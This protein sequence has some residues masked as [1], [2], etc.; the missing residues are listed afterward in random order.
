MRCPAEDGS[1]ARQ[2]KRGERKRARVMKPSSDDDGGGAE[3]CGPAAE[4]EQCSARGGAGDRA[5]AVGDHLSAARM[6]Y[7]TLLERLG[8]KGFRYSPLG[9][10]DGMLAQMLAEVDLRARVHARSR[11]SAGRACWRCAG[12]TAWI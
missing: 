2:A 11:R 1:N 5:E 8:L 3:D 10:R 4:D 9:L 12:G 6:V 7:A